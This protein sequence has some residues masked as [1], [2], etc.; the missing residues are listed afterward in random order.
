MLLFNNT[1]LLVWVTYFTVNSKDVICRDG[2]DRPVDSCPEGEQCFFP[3]GLNAT[4]GRF[5]GICVANNQT[6]PDASNR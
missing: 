3:A 2:V 4:T 1:F 5:F 6:K